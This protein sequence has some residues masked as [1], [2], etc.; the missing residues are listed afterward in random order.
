VGSWIGTALRQGHPPKF[1]VLLPFRGAHQRS[2]GL[3]SWASC[4]FRVFSGGSSPCP[5]AKAGSDAPPSGP[6]PRLMSLG[7]AGATSGLWALPFLFRTSVPG[8]PRA[9]RA[10][11]GPR[12]RRRLGGPPFRLAGV[13]RPGRLFRTTRVAIT[14]DAVSQKFATAVLNLDPDKLIRKLT[15]RRFSHPKHSRNRRV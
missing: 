9:L 6:T 14:V 2:L 11:A 4:F 15:K 5:F 10:P 13:L 8:P 7:P 1:Q 3:A 12:S